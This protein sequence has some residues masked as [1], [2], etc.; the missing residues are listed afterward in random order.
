LSNFNFNS[1]FV[2]QIED[3]NR[4]NIRIVRY[5]SHNFA[6][7]VERIYLNFEIIYIDATTLEVIEEMTHKVKVEGKDWVVSNDRIVTLIDAQGNEI[8][9]PDYDDSQPI[10][11]D[12]YPY[13]TGQ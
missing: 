8:A 1:I 7:H 11:S 4:G 12:N 9:N 6:D 5:L 2:S 10:T 3:D 13:K